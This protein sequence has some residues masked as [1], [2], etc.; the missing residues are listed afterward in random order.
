MKKT[1]ITISA[2]LSAW[3]VFLHANDRTPAERLSGRFLLQVES[4]GEAWYVDPRDL[5]KRLLGRPRD[6]FALMRQAGIGAKTADLAKLPIGLAPAVQDAD[7]DGLDDRLETA[8]GTDPAKT[9]TDGDGYDDKTEAENNYDPLAAG[10]I[11]VDRHSARRLSGKI[12]LQVESH[13]EAWYVNPLDLKRYYLGAPADAFNLI[14]RF[15]LGASNADLTKI[16]TSNSQSSAPAENSQTASYP[17]G[18]TDNRADSRPAADPSSSVLSGAASAIR[19][20]NA[21]AAAG[22]FTPAMKSSLEY[23]LKFLDADGRFA[24]GNILADAKLASTDE[25]EKIYSTEVYFAL[26]GSKV[27]V[28]F[29]VKKQPNGNW[30]LANL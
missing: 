9:D 17:E 5:K 16:K 23:T 19:A 20:N 8:I 25:E 26:G 27:P 6:A 21:K 2:I 11:A 1:I 12:L 4:R 30:L 7:S 22:Y 13:G 18:R 28:K 14:K 15:A 29:R 24:L 3:P 10:R